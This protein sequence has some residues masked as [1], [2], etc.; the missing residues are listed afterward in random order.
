MPSSFHCPRIR[1]D[2]KLSWNQSW[3][4]T[5]MSRPKLIGIL[6]DGRP[7]RRGAERG[8]AGDHARRGDVGRIGPH[9][10]KEVEGAGGERDQHDHK[11]P[12]QTG[13]GMAPTQQVGYTA[14]QEGRQRLG[15]GADEGADTLGPAP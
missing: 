7:T 13:D 15:S 5:D 14:E 8:P 4:P 11:G 6:V 10:P 3:R 9:G 12:S 1:S 2:W